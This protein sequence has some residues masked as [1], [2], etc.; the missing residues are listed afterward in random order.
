MIVKLLFQNIY[1]V[2]ID[3]NYHYLNS[4]ETHD[5]IMFDTKLKFPSTYL[6]AI[7][8]ETDIVI[9]NN[10]IFILMLLMK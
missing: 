2:A 3:L 5:D 10:V 7:R 6:W 8:I 9:L 1:L 4:R